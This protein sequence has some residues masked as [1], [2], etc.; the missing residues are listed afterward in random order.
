VCRPAAAAAAVGLERQLTSQIL[1][2]HP[3][4]AGVPQ[5]TTIETTSDVI[6]SAAETLKLVITSKSMD[7]ASTAA[8]C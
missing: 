4:L 7:D 1:V 5:C 6:V 3:C 8:R 2:R